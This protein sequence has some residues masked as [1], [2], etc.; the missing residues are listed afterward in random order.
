MLYEVITIEE[1]P[2]HE[3]TINFD[4]EFVPDSTA[5]PVWARYYDLEK[6]EPFLSLIDGTIVYHLCDISS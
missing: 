1:R 6:G 5:K 3:T 4:R 2:Y